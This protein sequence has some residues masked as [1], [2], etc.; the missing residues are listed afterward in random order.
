ME[1]CQPTLKKIILYIVFLGILSFNDRTY[2]FQLNIN[3]CKSEYQDPLKRLNA[4]EIGE[5]IENWISIIAIEFYQ[6]K[7]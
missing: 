2:D 3:I 1:Y 4:S 6:I 7:F 5:V